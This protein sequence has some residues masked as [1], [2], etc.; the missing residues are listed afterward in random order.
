MCLPLSPHFV[1][2]SIC[3][4]VGTTYSNVGTYSYVGICKNVCVCLYVFM[5]VYICVYIFVCVCVCVCV[6]SRATTMNSWLFCCFQVPAPP[7]DLLHQETDE[8]NTIRRRLEL[9]NCICRVSP[10]EASEHRNHAKLFFTTVEAIVTFP[11]WSVYIDPDVSSSVP[12]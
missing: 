4:H 2:V 9:L 1:C 8:N 7:C 6:H 11:S 5:F 3:M 10:M 12:P